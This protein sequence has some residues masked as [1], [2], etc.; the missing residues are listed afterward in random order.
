MS[1]VVSLDGTAIA[2]NTDVE[3]M[4]KAAV[5]L[6]ALLAKIEAGEIYPTRWLFIWDEPSKMLDANE[7]TE[8]RDSGMTIAQANLMIDSA[9][10]LW[11]RSLFGGTP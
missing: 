10:Y 8:C 3:D 7:K 1:K 6:K 2:G 9:K 11:M 5:A 4:H